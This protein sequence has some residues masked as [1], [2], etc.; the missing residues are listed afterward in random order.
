MK[1]F[2]VKIKD[3]EFRVLPVIDSEEM[4]KGLSGKPKLSTGKGM[5]FHFGE[6][7]EITMNMVGMRYPLD[8]LFIDGERKVKSVKT[9]KIGLNEVTVEGVMCVLEVNKGE[10]KDL[11]G[12]ELIPSEELVS[13]MMSSMEDQ[14]KDKEQEKEDTH[15][16]KEDPQGG[17]NIIV[18]ITSMPP[19]GKE[20][21]KKG[22]SFKIYEEDVKAR[23]GAMQVLDDG[24]RILMNIDGGE[25]IFS[26]EDTDNIVSLS[27]KI[28]SGEA[29]EDELGKLMEEIVI[30]QNT[31]KPEYV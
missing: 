28:D 18:K 22:G 26:I 17:F 15:T 23:Q 30:R 2:T 8:M 1:L 20:L 7:Q 10:G 27:K 25:R 16:E 13:F 21:F 31:Q 24:G 4:K 29:S 9:M 6:P 5:L 14:S 3:K 12:E 19:S 11:E